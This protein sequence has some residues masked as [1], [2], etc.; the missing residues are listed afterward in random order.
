MSFKKKTFSLLI[1]VV[2]LLASGAFLFA[3]KG[4]NSKEE[5]IMPPQIPTPFYAVSVTPEGELS[6]GVH[7][8]S[9]QVV[10]SE[11]VVPL[12]KLGEPILKSEHV[13]ITPKLEGVFRWYGTS[14]LSFDCADDLIPQKIYTVKINPE[15]VSVNGEKFSGQSEF[16]FFTE[17]IRMQKIVPGYLEQKKENIFFNSDDIPAEYAKNIAVNFSNKV[18]AKVISSHIEVRDSKNKKYN[19]SASQIEENSILLKIKNSFSQNEEITVTLKS[20]A[21]P[22]KG[23]RKTESEQAL[24]F[25]T[26]RPFE[27]VEASGGGTLRVSFNHAI[28]AGTEAD[29]LSAIS[30]APQFEIGLEQIKIEGNAI[31]V[32]DL[33]VTYSD[34]Y[35][36][37]IKENSVRDFYNQVCENK[38]ARKIQVGDAD[39]FADSRL[40]NFS[41]LESG[42][43]PKIAFEMQNIESE[44]SFYKIVPIAG[45]SEN[46]KLPSEKTF[47]A[48]TSAENKNRREIVTVDLSQFLQE[49]DDGERRGI[50]KFISEFYYKNYAGAKEESKHSR[51]AFIQVTDLGITV[52]ATPEK[53]IASV[54]SLKSGK[55]IS[56]AEIVL[57]QM[58]EERGKNGENYWEKVF[59][60]DGA[61]AISSQK[62][63]SDGIAVFEGSFDVS[64]NYFLLCR[65]KNDRAFLSLSAAQNSERQRT[66]IITQSDVFRPG[67]D[68]EIKVIDRTLKDGKYSN[69]QGGYVLRIVDRQYD[70]YR[71]ERKV[72]AEFSGSVSGQGTANA[73]W[74]VPEDAKPGNYF[75]EYE[76]RGAEKHQRQHAL[77]SVQY[78]ERLKF[79]ASAKITP[80]L[81][82]RGDTLTA[83]VS[84]SYL[85]GGSLSGGNARA[86][87]TRSQ[88]NFAPGGDYAE[89]VFGPALFSYLRSY[90]E[91]EYVEEDAEEENF[92]ESEQANLNDD[93][94]A[95]FSVKS[96]T[97]KIVGA[98]YAYN[99]QALVT[100]SSNQMIAARDSAIVHPASFYIGVKKLDGSR[101]F[102]K[103]G[104]KISFKYISLTPE[105]QVADSSLFSKEN[106]SWKLE[107]KIWKSEFYLDEYGIQQVRWKEVLEKESEGSLREREGE[108]S[109]VPKEGGNCILTL[110]GA[111]SK[112]RKVL[113]EFNFY[114]SG[115]EWVSPFARDDNSPKIELVADKEIYSVGEMASIA[116]NSNLSD[117][118]YLVT[119]CADG[120]F[121]SQVL[122]SSGNSAVI[123]IPIKENYLPKIE[124]RVSSHSHR[125]G[126][127]AGDY[128]SADEGKPRAA[129]A[130]IELD[131]SCETKSFEVKIDSKRKTYT[132]G[133]E[134]K[135]EL[136]ATK[137]DVPLQGAE[138][139]LV[140]VDK[141]VLNLSGYKITSPLDFFYD[142]N[143]FQTYSNY[144]DSRFR[145][146]DKLDY[147][148]Y[149]T[150][151]RER[152][153]IMYR[154]RLYAANGMVMEDAVEFE[155][156]YEYDMALPMAKAESGG[157]D[158]G[159]NE[160]VQVRNNFNMTAAFIPN[161]VTDENG[162]AVA[163]F[164]L[165]DTL[166]EYEVTVVGVSGDNFA[167][168][169][170]SVCVANP[171]SVR[172]VQTKILRPGDLGEAGVVIT[173]TSAEDKTVQIEFDVL[174]GLERTGY[175]RQDGELVRRNGNAKVSGESRKT[176]TVEAGKTKSVMFNLRAQDYGWVTLSFKA[177]CDGLNEVIYKGLEIQ[178]PYVYETVTTLGGVESEAQSALE[179][180]ILPS[181]SEDGKGSLFLQLDSTRLGTLASAVDYVF[182][183]PYGCLEQRSSAVMP[184][185]AFGDYIEVFGLQSEVDSPRE[186][187]QKEFGEW[188][189]AQK[190]DGGFPYWKDSGESSL[191]VSLRIAEILALAKEN[192]IEIPA[193]LDVRK[194]VSFIKKEFDECKKEKMQLYAQSYC[195]YVLSRMGEKFGAAELNEILENKNAS[196]NA[197]AFASLAALENGERKLAEYAVAKIKNAMALTTR[198]VTFQSGDFE[199][200]H[201]FGGK[202]EQYALCLELFAKLVASDIYVSRIVYEMLEMQRAFKGA[203]HSTAETSRALI[204]LAS[205]I[206]LAGLEDS[207]FSAQVLL[208]GNKLLEG[209]FKGA[210][211]NPVNAQ[212]DFADEE[213]ASLEKEKEIPLEI[214]KQ[215]KGAL[216]YTASMKYAI[217]AEEQLAR[218]EGLC[219]YTEIT[220]ARTGEKVEA[221]K[222]KSG[223]IYRQKVFVTT[224]KDRTFVALRAAVPAGCEIMNAAFV[225]TATVSQK[226]DAAENGAKTWY[227]PWRM[228]HQDIYDAEIRCFWN[229]L[230]AGTQSFEF[231]FRAERKGTYQT[232]AVLAEC[233]YEGEIFGRSAGYECRIE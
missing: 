67:D 204:A 33:P 203:W 31:T 132:P 48:K 191:A 194:L 208:D 185:V 38:I 90:D 97:E 130:S 216:Y 134:V 84:A 231:L 121:E 27:F 83:N 104:E 76:R 50:V 17:E 180:I 143:F 227:S 51:E 44:K 94:A 158:G 8:P 152:E 163:T 186:A 183:Y 93:G 115:E 146:L 77:F 140:A 181:L 47:A 201:F 64:K 24:K 120:V 125:S 122:K 225:T 118:D 56:D 169:S 2:L 73:K 75:V 178:K 177:K 40:G 155:S 23:Y 222:L 85:G 21:E 108:F 145:L 10:F 89:Y 148:S 82:T 142:R 219:V 12:A 37:E 214:K 147:E 167:L 78:F 221:A 160:G 16:N 170:Q 224:T 157:A 139:A 55:A 198:G 215:G 218:D 141:G 92:Y 65:T 175:K 168:A 184:L 102:A 179:K 45:V 211:A 171:V 105:A 113:T 182:H 5:K 187:V 79:S 1:F 74:R 212:F 42:A 138:L 223:E 53:I 159:T 200:W 52:R 124:V 149:T 210:D 88:T 127:G 41:F 114:A 117:A 35:S 166:T 66:Q 226:G 109:V 172:D 29:I 86:E 116:L 25:H 72:F 112:G 11:P 106:F 99:L 28:K 206:K 213:I 71:N 154:N 80:I 150:A 128:D 19:F 22:Q 217:P 153:L 126:N 14:V 135:I 207:D 7:H 174:Q 58:P 123:E 20:G 230:A 193:S 131:V 95:N 43:N 119:V 61:K 69:Y 197:L 162:R 60:L 232:P 195:M 39:V 176:V 32:S 70:Y 68:V 151:A 26:L 188:A 111:D 137:N 107:R 59:R 49:C 103:T 91:G 173:N 209:E 4:K 220:D 199:C 15:I 9:I 6:S 161:L 3:A 110:S 63:S 87:W 30:F 98:P 136:Q 192:K 96:G 164:K 34:E 81:Y 133:S 165:P 46:F 190:N 18:S 54:S 129:H 228:S 233:M 62:T 57:F 205:Y 202:I 36:F 229:Y 144:D 189:A 100:D 101:G 13:E 196:I 156:A